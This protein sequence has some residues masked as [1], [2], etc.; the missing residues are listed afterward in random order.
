MTL[1]RKF[2]RLPPITCGFDDKLPELGALADSI[3][4]G[5]VYDGFISPAEKQDHSDPITIP[6]HI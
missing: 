1:S 3:I 6:G 4:Q 5:E 2:R